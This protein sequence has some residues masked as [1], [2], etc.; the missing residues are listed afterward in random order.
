MPD[1]TLPFRPSA[2]GCAWSGRAAAGQWTTC[3]A[4]TVQAAVWTSPAGKRWRV[5][6]C[7]AHADRLDRGHPLDD[8]DRAELADRR[9]RWNDAL[10][11]KG[12]RPPRPM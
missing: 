3:N 8:A 2:P 10:A 1:D 5:Y 11:G 9:T 7:A 6:G 4:E 12:W